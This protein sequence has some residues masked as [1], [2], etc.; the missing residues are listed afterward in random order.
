MFRV[1]GKDEVRRRRQYFKT[2]R[3]QLTDHVL[4]AADDRLAGLREIVTVGKSSSRTNDGDA[5]QRVG[6]ETVFNPLQGLDQ[7]RMAHRQAH[8]QTSQ[9]ARFGQGLGHQQVRVAVH[10]ADGGFATKVDVGFV[11]HNH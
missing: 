5:V 7:V 1:A 2:Q 4:A 11:H 8:P 10:Q 3:L 9:R 6:V